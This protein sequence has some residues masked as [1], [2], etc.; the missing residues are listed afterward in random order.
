M[1]VNW[2]F[3]E[4]LDGHHNANLWLLWPTDFLFA[5]AGWRLLRPAKKSPRPS[6]VWRIGV[7]GAAAAHL[8]A[9]LGA[10]GLFLGGAICQDLSRVLLYLAPGMALSYVLVVLRAKSS[11]GAS[12]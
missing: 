6:L 10:A 12:G 9:L 4:H 2:L 7:E 3:S 5:W 1:V 8:A 11:C